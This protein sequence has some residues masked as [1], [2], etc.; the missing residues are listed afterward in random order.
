MPRTLGTSPQVIPSGRPMGGNPPWTAP[1]TA[2]PCDAASRL[3]DTMIDRTTAMTAPGTL[4]ANRLNPMI[5]TSVPAANPTVQAL[6]SDTCVMVHHCCSNQFPDPFGMPSMPGTCPEKHLD[7]DAGQEPD[8]HRRAQEVAEEAEL[9]QSGEDQQTAADERHEAG[10]GQPLG[11][12][13]LQPGDP[14]PGQPGGE[15]R[16]GGGVRPD[17]QQP[18]RAE[19]REHDRREDDR[20]EAGDHG[21]LRDRRVAHGLRDRHGRQRHAGDHV[22][23]QPGRLVAA[24]RLG[25]E[26]GHETSGLDGRAARDRP[27]AP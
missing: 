11:R 15:D 12:V 9:E 24:H 8:E 10:P 13:R 27:R 5:R 26:L 20:V 1:T 23:R 6:A 3:A 22:P 14:E 7:P 19:Q 2:T 25:R 21:R 16:R 18:R 4:G 17:D